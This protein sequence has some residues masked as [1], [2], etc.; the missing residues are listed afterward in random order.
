VDAVGVGGSDAGGA[1]GVGDVGVAWERW[2]P[3][4]GYALSGGAICY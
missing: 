4:T 1:G 2:Y 3:F